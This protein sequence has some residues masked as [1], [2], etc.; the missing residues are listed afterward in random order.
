PTRLIGRDK[1]FDADQEAWDWVR[2]HPGWVVTEFGNP[3]QTVE[4]Q[5]KNGTV[6]FR[7]AGNQQ[8]G[9][10]DGVIGSKAA[11]APFSTGPLGETLMLDAQPSASASRLATTV[12]RSLFA[13]GIDA[14]TTRSLLDKAY[15]AN[16]TFFSVIQVLMQ[17]GLVV[18]ILALGI[19]SLRAVVERRHVIGVLRAI[20]YRKRRVMGGLM[21]ESG[22]AA[23]L[24]VVVGVAAGFVM[25]FIY[26]KQFGNG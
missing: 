6:T 7:I 3:G 5:G 16:R 24:G 13:Q 18:G 8:G 11:L 14:A 15:R 17:M 2:S 9:I 10:L 21:A 12:E 23:T 22:V 20:G 19:V 25:G 4:L 26:W 1:R